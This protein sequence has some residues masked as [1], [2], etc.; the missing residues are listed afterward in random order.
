MNAIARWSRPERTEGPASSG[1]HYSRAFQ[2]ISQQTS[3]RS[4]ADMPAAGV[5]YPSDQPCGGGQGSSHLVVR[6]KG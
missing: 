4:M 5:I 3:I 1:L 6:C 2:R